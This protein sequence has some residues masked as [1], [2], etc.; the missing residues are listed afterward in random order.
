MPVIKQVIKNRLKLFIEK[1]KANENVD[2]AVEQFTEE[3]SSIIRDAILS[4]T[5]TAPPGSIIV[6]GG[7]TTQS[8]VQPIIFNIQ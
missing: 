7:P 6:V 5:V 8:N 1:N 2:D 4:A 3:L